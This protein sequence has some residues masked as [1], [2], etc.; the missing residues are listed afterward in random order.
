MSVDLGSLIEVVWEDIVAHSGWVQAQDLEQA[1]AVIV[2]IG[3]LTVETDKFITV[4]ATQGTMA[5]VTEYN[6]HIT[7][8]KGCLLSIKKLEPITVPAI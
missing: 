5:L 1:P 3:W 6:Q 8:P 7:I 2:S 4:S